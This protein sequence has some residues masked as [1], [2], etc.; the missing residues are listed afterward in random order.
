MEI[1][2]NAQGRYYHIDCRPGD[3]GRYILTCGDRNRCRN[4]ASHF[5]STE[6]VRDNRDFLTITGRYKGIEISAL[7]AGIG[8]AAAAIAMVEI[9]QCSPEATIIRVG[10]CGG[11]QDHVNAG[12]LIVTE[13]ALRDEDTTLCYAGPEVEATADPDVCAA[14]VEAC[15]V[16]GF[17]Y[18]VGVTCTTSDFYA[19]QGRVVP[20]FPTLDPEKVERMRRE[21]VLNFE[22]EM[23]VFL[24]LARVSSFNVRAGGV[25]AVFAERTRGVFASSELLQEYE[26][27]CIQAGLLAVELLD[28]PDASAKL[29]P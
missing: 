28:R 9:C 2:R 23:S 3:V 17:A 16:L 25:C 6:I 29:L 15:R 1:P 8:P 11:L 20:G 26:M 19:G 14:L 22:M 10:S 5:D 27:R 12:D 24:T 21:G 13:R 7:C 4:I 18:H